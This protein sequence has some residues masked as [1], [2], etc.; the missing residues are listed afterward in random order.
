VADGEETPYTAARTLLATFL[1][2]NQ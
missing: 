1:E 2:E